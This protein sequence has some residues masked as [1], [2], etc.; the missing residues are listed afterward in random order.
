MNEMKTKFPWAT[1][2]VCILVVG[3]I[4]LSFR[5]GIFWQSVV[6]SREPIR[7]SHLTPGNGWEYKLICLDS[8]VHFVMPLDGTMVA[9]VKDVRVEK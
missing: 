5:V 2:A 7:V 6:L 3:L 1:I 9:T 8:N 4:A